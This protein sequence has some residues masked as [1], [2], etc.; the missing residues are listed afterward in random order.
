MKLIPIDGQDL[1][2]KVVLLSADDYRGDDNARL[3][4]CEGGFGCKPYHGRSIM[5]TFLE[6]GEKARVSRLSVAGI[7][8]PQPVAEPPGLG[9]IIEAQGWD[10]TT[11]KN[12]LFDFIATKDLD[13]ALRSYLAD[14]AATENGG[15][16]ASREPERPISMHIY[17]EAKG[18]LDVVFERPGRVSISRYSDG[19]P[20]VYVY[21]GTSTDERNEP[22]GCFD[23]S[24]PNNSGFVK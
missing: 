13:G 9:A 22:I 17:D 1:E 4:R 20:L 15:E 11:V 19:K 23:G 6:D 8:D 21:D 3:F 10:D 16:V 2:G 12:L 18:Q 24:E 14:A 7:V 5:G